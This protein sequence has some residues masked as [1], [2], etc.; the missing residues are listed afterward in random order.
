MRDLVGPIGL[1]VLQSTGF[2]NIDCSYCYLPNRSDPRRTMDLA[3]VARVAQL[4]FDS[5]LLKGDIDLVWHAGEPLSL[6]PQYYSQAIE[7]IEKV[8]PSGVAVHYG[9]QTNGTLIDDEWIDLFKRH[10]FNVGISLD[11]PRDLHDAN[12]KYRSGQGSYDRVTAGISRLQARGYPFHVIGVLTELSLTRV[13][14]LVKFYW[15]LRP[16]AIGLNVEEIE[17]RNR[18]SSLFDAL[19]GKKF[20]CFVTEFLNE[21]AMQEF[22]IEIRDFART[23]SWLIVGKPEDN[24]QVVPLRILNVAW[25]GDLSTFSPELLAL[26]GAESRRFVFGNV[27]D[28]RALTEMLDDKRFVAAFREI[29]R[30][31]AKCAD[32]CEY[33]RVCDGG[34]PVNKLSETGRLDTTE[35]NFCR[36]TK[37]T[38]VDACL[39][40]ASSIDS[41]FELTT[42]V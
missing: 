23:M 5:P 22:R 35:T 20:D 21:A 42:V 9:V 4:I 38:W 3:T 1:V 7:V 29:S 15:Q 36:L 39:Q 41:R 33:F 32:E 16:T 6:P 31:V 14:D 27:R 28:C 2:C 24:D 17:A 11:G 34:A 12:R 10:Q 19:R 25:N 26:T 8:K 18:H 30:G 37:K 13:Q 40:F